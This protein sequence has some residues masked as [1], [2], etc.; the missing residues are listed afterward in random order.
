MITQDSIQE[1]AQRWRLWLSKRLQ[2]AIGRLRARY[3]LRGAII[4][5]GV[6]ATGRIK[7]SNQGTLY[8]GRKVTFLG[9]MIPTQ[10]I[11]HRGARLDIGDETLFNY[12]ASIEVWNELTIGRRCMIASMVRIADGPGQTA[13]VVR[14]GDNVWIAHG[15][16]IGPSAIIGEG[17]TLA[18]GSVLDRDVPPQTLAIGDPARFVG[19]NL[20]AGLSGRSST[21]TATSPTG[22]VLS[23]ESFQ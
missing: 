8:I 21:T 7:I 14:L 11:I 9:G 23:K 15:A 5:R 10:I 2:R 3:M 6:C 20:L 17:S 22:A 18:A 13:S 1:L 19:L 12:G 4:G 16:T